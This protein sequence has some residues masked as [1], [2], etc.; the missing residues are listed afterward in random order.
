[1]IVVRENGLQI[2]VWCTSD[3]DGNPFFHPDEPRQ[4]LDHI[5]W[6]WVEDLWV[7]LEIPPGVDDKLAWLL[8]NGLVP[9]QLFLVRIRRPR[10]YQDYFGE[11]GVDYG[12]WE[13][14]ERAPVEDAGEIWCDRFEF[15]QV[16]GLWR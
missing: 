4:S 8:R 7:M 6:A 11:W 1:V 9:G 14:L 16:K 2:D 5:S 15:K 12:D 3:E 13:I 10:Y